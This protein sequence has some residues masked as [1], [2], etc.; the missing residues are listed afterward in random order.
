MLNENDSSVRSERLTNSGLTNC[1]KQSSMSKGVRNFFF[2]ENFV[3]NDEGKMTRESGKNTLDLKFLNKMR[4][5]LNTFTRDEK[6][7]IVVKWYVTDEK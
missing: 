1:I 3:K 4:H 6:S 5:L 2:H 7:R